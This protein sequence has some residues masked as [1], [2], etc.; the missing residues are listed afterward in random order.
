MEN[1][2]SGLRSIITLDKKKFLSGGNIKT[3]LLLHIILF[4]FS[5]S[6]VCSKMAAKQEFLSFKFIL[7]YG[8]VLFILFVYAIAWQ[9]VLKRLPLVTAYANKAV[10]VIWG[11]VFGLVFF[12]EKITVQKVIG[13]VIIILGVY[14]IVSD[15]E[16]TK[17]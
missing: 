14:L 12:Q 1:S 13:A 9:Q 7:F 16:E 8:L 5:L 15:G 2:L 17:A 3:Y 11:L 10:T 4:G 6:S